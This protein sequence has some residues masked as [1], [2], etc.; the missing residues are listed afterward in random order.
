MGDIKMRWQKV[1]EEI[2]IGKD[3][4]N[5]GVKVNRKFQSSETKNID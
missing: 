5:K 1:E 4:K 3:T 2:R